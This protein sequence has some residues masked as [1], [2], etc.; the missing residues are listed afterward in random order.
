MSKP[1]TAPYDCPAWFD[2]RR[3][4]LFLLV[5]EARSFTKAATRLGLSQT[6]L[7][8]H[9]RTLEVAAGLRVFYRD[10]RGVQLTEAG[11]RLQERA[12]NIMQEVAA[13]QLEMTSAD[14]AP[15]GLVTLGMQPAISAILS[16]PVAIK[17]MS[18]LPHAR[19]HIMEGMSGH[20]LDWLMAG[21]VDVALHYDQPNLGRS[22]AEP[23][24]TQ[25]LLLVG[26]PD[27]GMSLEA[28]VAASRL[29]EVPLILPGRPHGLRLTLDAHAT[30]KGYA[31]Q[32]PIEMD[33]PSGIIGL[34]ASGAG[35]SVLPLA[36]IQDACNAGRVCASWIVKPRI[37]RTLLMS[38]AAHKPL[39]A[40]VR[41]FMQ[42]IRQEARRISSQS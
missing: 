13:A 37:T 8:R 25:D 28:T 38:I 42:I 22:N 40:T 4:A 1:N 27:A 19:L 5:A 18:L 34:V 32:V 2:P 21:R 17:A 33:S 39:T 14:S 6:S 41:R 3:V 29:A 7:S 10:G 36:S 11:K 15:A 26:P 30:R 23:L 20:I 35:Y 12:R 31:L 24:L 9:I 16:V